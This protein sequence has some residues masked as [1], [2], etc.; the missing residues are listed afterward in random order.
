MPRPTPA[1]PESVRAPS[2]PANLDFVS[3]GRASSLMT[4][5]ALGR[6]RRSRCKK[7]H[8]ECHAPSG[9]TN[10]TRCP[11]IHADLLLYSWKAYT[12]AQSLGRPVSMAQAQLPARRAVCVNVA[13]GSKSPV[14]SSTSPSQ[15]RGFLR[16]ATDTSSSKAEEEVQAVSILVDSGSQQDP[17]CSTVLAQRL[18]AQGTFSSYAVQAGGQ[19]LPIYDVGW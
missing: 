1:S 16:K 3:V 2:T 13:G 6:V 10:G 9:D 11:T 15:H 18:G 8:Q 14:G 4:H 7:T 17:L 19:P 5:E 12:L